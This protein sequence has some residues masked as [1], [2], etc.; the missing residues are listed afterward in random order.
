MA[1]PARRLVPRKDRSNGGAA[2]VEIKR[3]EDCSA[4]DV[5]TLSSSSKKAPRSSAKKR[6]LVQVDDEVFVDVDVTSAAAVASDDE[7]DD[8]VQVVAQ[9]EF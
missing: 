6:T 5:F 8:N 3:L 2:L 4:D 9:L 1:T 7:A